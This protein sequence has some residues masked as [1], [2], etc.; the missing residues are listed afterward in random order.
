[1]A[2]IEPWDLRVSPANP[3]ELP[4]DIA[5]KLRTPDAVEELSDA[6]RVKLKIESGLD[7]GHFQRNRDRFIHVGPVVTVRYAPK[8]IWDNEHRLGHDAIGAA[9][10]PGCVVLTDAS[11]CPDSVLGGVAAQTIRRG[12]A[13]VVVID[14]L[15]RDIDEVTEAGLTVMAA[16]FGVRSGRPMAQAIAINEPMRFVGTY[17][18]TGDIA[19]VNQHGL[20]VIPS[21]LGWDDLRSAL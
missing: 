9:C 2:L 14:G 6:L 7:L 12:G 17:V 1:M 4:A 16:R 3:R 5:A 13:D 8:R 21:W 10:V 15:A 20:V 11:G 19:V 18:A